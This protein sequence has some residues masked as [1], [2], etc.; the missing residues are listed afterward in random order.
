MRRARSG[1]SNDI[2]R[3]GRSITINEGEIIDG[4]VVGIGG[5]VRVDGEVRGDVVSVGGGLTLGPGAYVTDNVVAVGGALRRD[6]S[7]R[8]DG[9]VSEIGGFDFGDFDWG[10]AIGPMWMGSWFSSTFRLVTTLTHT[11]VLCLLTALVLLIAQQYADRASLRAASETA[12]AFAV[13]FLAEILF[14]PVLVIT[15]VVLTVT[16]I[17]IPLLL[18]IPFA[19]L[20]L[21]IL[22]LVG[23][24][25]VAHYVGEQVAQRFGWSV[26]L[27][28][29][30]ILGV[31]AVMSPLLLSRVIGL[32]GFMGVGPFSFGLA[33]LG[34]AVYFGA[35]TIGF[36]SV[37][38]MRFNRSTPPA[39]VVGP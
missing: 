37:A 1:N 35:W 28:S 32:V 25:G 39:V 13:G 14:L 33:L 22:A 21:M 2:V 34:W 26:N 6:P 4:D 10:R 7:A 8:I 5:P 16:I 18:L 12:K 9:R 24:T 36:G 31:V 27:Y 38:L 29:A 20:G 23:F 30:T 17:G 3:L 11:A 15:I 19:L